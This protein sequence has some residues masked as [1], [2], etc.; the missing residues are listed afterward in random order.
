MI[1]TM[2]GL[3]HHYPELQVKKSPSTYWVKKGWHSY[4][5]FNQ[6]PQ[7]FHELNKDELKNIHYFK[8]FVQA[9][10]FSLERYM[11]KIALMLLHF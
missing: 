6:V 2:V 10:F 9:S 11:E 4:Y 7:P 5:S 1:R 8:Q 3:Y